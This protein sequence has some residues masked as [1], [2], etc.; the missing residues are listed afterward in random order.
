MGGAMEV[1][2]SG[3]MNS[4]AP[5]PPSPLSPLAPSSL[6]LPPSLPLSS[7]LA[8]DHINIPLKPVSTAARSPSPSPPP[9]LLRTIFFFFLFPLFPPSC[10]SDSLPCHCFI[11][12]IAFPPISLTGASGR[13]SF[14]T[15]SQEFP[16]LHTCTRVCTHAHTHIH[17]HRGGGYRCL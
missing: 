1:G 4:C 7:A 6:P 3:V 17:T 5:F 16:L 11:E 2:G 12:G 14:I 10:F 8:Q 13:G 9:S 15:F